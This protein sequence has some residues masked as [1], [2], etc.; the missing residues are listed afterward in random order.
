MPR[1]VST[2]P[3]SRTAVYS[4]IS[5]RPSRRGRR[6]SWWRRSVGRRRGS[7]LVAVVGARD[8][9]PSPAILWVG[10]DPSQFRP[11]VLSCLENAVSAAAES[12]R[13]GT[14]RRRSRF[15][16]DGR[17]ALWQ[18]RL[19]GKRVLL[20]LDDARDVDQIEPLLPA[21]V[22]CLTLVTRSATA[23]RPR[24]RGAP[25]AGNPCSQLGR[26]AFHDAGAARPGRRPAAHRGRACRRIVRLPAIGDHPADRPTGAPFYMD[27]CRRRRRIQRG[28]RS[29]RRTRCE[30]QGLFVPRSICPTGDLAPEQKLLFRRLG[31]HPGPDLDAAAPAALIGVDATTARQKLETLYTDHLLDEPTRGRFRMYD[32]LREYAR[33]LSAAKPSCGHAAALDRLLDCY[34]HTAT[35]ADRWLARYNRPASD[36]SPVHSA[37]AR[38]FADDIAALH[39]LRTERDKLLACLDDTESQDPTRTVALTAALAGLMD[40]D[41]PRPL[42]RQLHECALAVGDRLGKAN[43]LT[44]LGAVPWRVGNYGVATDRLEAALTLYSEFG[45]RLGETGQWPE[46]S[47]YCPWALWTPR[48]GC[49]PTGTG[50]VPA[51]R[52]PPR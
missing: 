50:P 22:E 46:Q 25:A 21:T 11:R 17:R 30:H 20:V 45:N 13:C 23:D 44:N 10:V 27:N 6:R 3:P 18:D 31:L 26:S 40:R 38:E 47:R 42:A 33:A 28:G 12:S 8:L 1:Q 29:T 37:P 19:T 2:C 15:T 34:Q 32:P 36:E 5:A 43:T 41:G 48:R 16:L 24:R 39:W 4:S 49:R 14:P 51:T 9:S 7:R 52:S 35:A